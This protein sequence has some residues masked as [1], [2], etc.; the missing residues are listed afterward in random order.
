M[1]FL[2]KAFL[3]TR[4][5]L[6]RQTMIEYALILGAIAIAV[7]VTHQIMGQDINSLMNSVDSLL[8]ATR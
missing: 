8:T 5:Q 7:F 1:H 4:Q 3:K 2:N 6:S